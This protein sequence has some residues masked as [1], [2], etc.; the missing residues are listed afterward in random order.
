MLHNLCVNAGEN[1]LSAGKEGAIRVV[2]VVQRK[3]G[4]FGWLLALVCE[5]LHNMCQN[6]R[7]NWT[8]ARK[9]GAIRVVVMVLRM[10][11]ES[12][13]LLASA[14]CWLLK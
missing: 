8:A 4:A 2:V 14:S 6:D 12:H 11:G 7:E 9:E 1:R 10:T 5:L 3:Q 13:G